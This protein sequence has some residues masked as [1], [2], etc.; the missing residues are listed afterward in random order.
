MKMLNSL[1]PALVTGLTLLAATL[2][3]VTAD[4]PGAAELLCYGTAVKTTSA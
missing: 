1:P 4:T 2:Q 3:G